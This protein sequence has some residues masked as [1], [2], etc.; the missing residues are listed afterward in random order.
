M[1]V[2]AQLLERGPV[3]FDGAMGTELFARDVPAEC[4]L[5]ELNLTD[6]IKVTGIHRDYIAAGADAI[7]T[8]TFGANRFGLGEHYLEQLVQ[9]INRAGAR[10]AVEARNASGRPVLVAGSVGPLGRPIEPVGA[11]KRSSAERI[12]GEQVQA[13]AEA[14]V[15]LLVLETFTALGELEAAV[16]AAR[17][18]APQLPIVAHMSFDDEANPAQAAAALVRALEPLRV[19]GIG[20]NCGSGPAAALEVTAHLAAAGARNIS[21]MPNA[22][23]PQR[24]GGRLVYSTGPEYFADVAERLV[25]AGARIVG[26]C[27]GT[28][29]RHIALIRD[30][31]AG[32]GDP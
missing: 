29:P 26:G 2:L 15:D 21:V 24:V 31:L 6:P 3:L 10:L 23:L 20:A 19:S 4:C 28:G 1:D 14:G 16:E 7:E 27:C 13:L 9:Q 22:G 32:T 11:I 30:R 25:S 18:T 5:E 12:F 17:A 8:N